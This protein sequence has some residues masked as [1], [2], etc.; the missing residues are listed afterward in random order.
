[1]LQ[2]DGEDLAVPTGL[3]RQQFSLLAPP[4]SLLFSL[5]EFIVSHGIIVVIRLCSAKFKL[6]NR[7]N[8]LSM[9]IRAAETGSQV[10]AS[11]ARFLFLVLVWLARVVPNRFRSSAMLA[12]PGNRRNAAGL[13]SIKLDQTPSMI[14]MSRSAPSPSA[15]K[16]SP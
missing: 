2:L 12:N 13:R 4:N 3:F 5:V 7:E 16:A 6:E 11:T 15:R 10:T 8:T 14:R 1:M 9:G